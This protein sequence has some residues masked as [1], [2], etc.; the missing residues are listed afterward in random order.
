MDRIRKIEPQRPPLRKDAAPRRPAAPPLLQPL[1]EGEE[2]LLRRRQKSI[3]VESEIPGSPPDSQLLNQPQGP[4]R[5]AG[6][7]PG[8]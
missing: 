8:L 1:Q 6:L 5:T 2:P 7:K 3:I 4:L